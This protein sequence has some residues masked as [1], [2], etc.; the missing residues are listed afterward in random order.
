LC[1]NFKVKAFIAA[2]YV[3]CFIKSI[4]AT[5]LSNL[6]DA[7]TKEWPATIKKIQQKFK[8]PNLIIPVTTTG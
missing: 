5:Y 7:N 6:G 4:E 2:W 3:G 8:D 1:L